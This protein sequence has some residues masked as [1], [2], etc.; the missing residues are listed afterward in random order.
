MLDPK[1]L[2]HQALRDRILD[3]QNGLHEGDLNAEEANEYYAHLEALKAELMERNDSQIIQ[4]LS[5]K[6]RPL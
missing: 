5:T 3:I 1:T 6:R 2:D 4:F